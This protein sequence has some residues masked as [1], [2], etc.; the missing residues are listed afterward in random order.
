MKHIHHLAS[1]LASL[2]RGRD[3]TLVHMSKDEVRGLAAL[4]PGGKLKINPNTGL[5]EADSLG[6]ILGVL[7]GIAG[8]AAAPFTGGASLALDAGLG[9]GLGTFAGNLIDGQPFGSSLLQGVGSGLL[10]YGLGSAT[11]L[12]AAA[13]PAVGDASMMSS[14][15]AGAVAPAAAPASANA[16]QA[17]GGDSYNMIDPN[18]VDPYT[19]AQ[20]SVPLNPVTMYPNTSGTG[21]MTGYPLNSTSPWATAQAAGQNLTNPSALWNT[22]GTNAMKT[23]LPIVGGAA[24]SGMVGDPLGLYSQTPAA[25]YQGQPT[26]NYP[27]L[28]GPNQRQYVPAPANWDYST[29]NTWNYFTPAFAGGG[30]VDGRRKDF[31]GPTQEFDVDD[32]DA[33][34][35][36]VPQAVIPTWNFS[37][38][39]SVYPP[40]AAIKQYDSGGGISD[41][42][43]ATS[44]YG[45]NPQVT[46]GQNGLPQVANIPAI[47]SFYQ[48][49][50][51]YGPNGLPL[52]FGHFQSPMAQRAQAAQA[53]MQQQPQGQQVAQM[54]QPGPAGPT[55]GLASGGSVLDATKVN[56]KSPFTLAQ[57]PFHGSTARLGSPPR[58]A[59][60]LGAPPQM[61]QQMPMM[62]WLPPMRR[63]F[64]PAAAAHMAKGGW[65]AG[66]I[67]H[68]GALTRQAHAAGQSPMEFA[69]AHKH[70]SG[71]TGNR[72]RLALTLSHFDDGGGVPAAQMGMP[73]IPTPP[74]GGGISG[75]GSG[76]DDAI[77]AVVNGRKPAALSSGEFVVPAHAVSGLGN[78]STEDGV[79]HLKGMVSR[80]MRHKFGTA[81]RKP[82]PLNPAKFLPA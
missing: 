47:Q 41:V 11:D 39:N 30:K 26:T 2:G 70:D 21:A 45:S 73:G 29:G 40:S 7:G 15:G 72:A 74:M 81:S 48:N 54:Q 78:G 38:P 50:Y 37:T 66:A 51:N 42:A 82:H 4:A 68:P 44:Q 46:F 33:S 14:T 32:E 55:M 58:M 59:R 28:P 25:I 80:I 52:S 64:A 18:M 79:R 24:M 43:S 69:N 27:T 53:Q 63:P 62:R 65:I 1:G 31:N 49:R 19:A 8:V 34:Q 10:G 22:F 60:H 77:P 17:I 71:V 3:D 12:L 35:W 36:P 75:P 61:A 9:A 57:T 23:T 16:A 6:S 13:N 67:K 56:D 5:P 76:L 20:N